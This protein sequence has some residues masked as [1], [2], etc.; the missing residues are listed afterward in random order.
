V[1]TNDLQRFVFI[2][3][4]LLQFCLFQTHN[5]EVESSSLSRTTSALLAFAPGLLQE[6][7]HVLALPQTFRCPAL[8]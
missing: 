5:R 4:Y 2:I 8:R 1:I 3:L 7:I 6:H